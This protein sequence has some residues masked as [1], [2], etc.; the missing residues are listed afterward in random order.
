MHGLGKGS[1]FSPPLPSQKIKK[2]SLRNFIFPKDE[3]DCE[4]RPQ[5]PLP[6]TGSIQTVQAF[7]CF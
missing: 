6:R 3:P 1:I 7:V 5:S 4:A 2:S